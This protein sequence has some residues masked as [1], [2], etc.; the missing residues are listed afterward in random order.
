MGYHSSDYDHDWAIGAPE[1]TRTI[2]LFNTKYSATGLRS[3]CYKVDPSTIDGFAPDTARNPEVA[4]TLSTYHSA[5]YNQDGKIDQEEIDRVTLLYN[6]RVNNVRTGSY[7]VDHTTIDGF[8]Q[9]AYPYKVTLS[10]YTFDDTQRPIISSQANLYAEDG[11]TYYKL[12]C[13]FL[14]GS[15][16]GLMGTEETNNN[17]RA[18]TTLP[19]PGTYEVELYYVQYSYG[20]FEADYDNDGVVTADDYAAIGEVAASIL[21]QPT[22]SQYMRSDCAPTTTL[23]S[24]DA[25]G[26]SDWVQSGRY[27]LGY[28]Q[29]VPVGG[30]GTPDADPAL[31]G[32]VGIKTFA[33]VTI[34]ALTQQGQCVPAQ[35]EVDCDAPSLPLGPCPGEAFTTTYNPDAAKKFSV[36]ANL[37]DRNCYDILDNNDKVILTVIQ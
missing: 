27:Y 9:Y 17:N 24:G 30:P 35:L 2:V 5:D 14:D 33:T 15:V 3:G 10:S 19:P 31:V 36:T 1:L 29:T 23:G 13:K 12:R 26:N 25:V 28:D 4:V 34:N 32:H 37:K 21:P 22:G 7:H 6:T 8:D 16:D 11:K 20:G 18:L